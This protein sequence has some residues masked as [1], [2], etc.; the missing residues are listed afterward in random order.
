MF[1]PRF[2]KASEQIASVLI[3]RFTTCHKVDEIVDTKVSKVK[4][5]IQAAL[6]VAATHEVSYT[7]S[8][9]DPGLENGGYDNLS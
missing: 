6:V 5:H 1:R 7:V 3:P 8:F 2:D 9:S 4:Y